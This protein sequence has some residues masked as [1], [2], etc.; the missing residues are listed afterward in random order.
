MVSTD[1]YSLSEQTISMA[2]TP[3]QKQTKIKQGG[4]IIDKESNDSDLL[5]V[6]DVTDIPASDW[7]IFETPPQDPDITVASENQ[8]HPANSSV[9]LAV[10]LSSL[11]NKL[12][13]WSPET[14]VEQYTSD[15]LPR[16]ITPYAFP[17]SRLKSASK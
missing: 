5:L 10:Y 14:I 13:D 11:N 3:K 1:N 15:E 17:E 12:S 4:W 6:L 7:V 8:N 2:S 9:I 16:G